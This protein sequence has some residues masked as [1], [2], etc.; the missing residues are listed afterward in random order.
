MSVADATSVITAVSN[1]KL[2]FITTV[3][4]FVAMKNTVKVPL[5]IGKLV[6]SNLDTMNAAVQAFEAVLTAKA[7][8][9]PSLTSAQNGR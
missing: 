9:G 5:L 3:D 4:N 2:D 8:V 7:P 1:L 6:K